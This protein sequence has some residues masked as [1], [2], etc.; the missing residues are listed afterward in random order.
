MKIKRITT[1]LG[2]LMSLC[3]LPLAVAD[4]LTVVIENVAVSEGII[5]LQVMS[6][7]EEFD[8]TAEPAASLL[9][10]ANAG[11][12][13]FSA[14][15][16][17]AGEYAVRIMH[18]RNGNNELDSNFVG[19]PTEPWGFSNNAAGNFGPPTWADAKFT[20]EDSVTQNVRLNQ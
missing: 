17:P 4:S 7:P 20:L 15:G 18:D 1:L 10:R 3:W 19:M 9:L 11:Q 2:A 16:L 6:G 8:G 12:M 14:T 13:S 5:M